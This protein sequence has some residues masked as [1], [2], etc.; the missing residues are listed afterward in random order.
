VSR[1]EWVRLWDKGDL[2]EVQ[3]GIRELNAVISTPG[4]RRGGRVEPL[5]G[6]EQLTPR[7][8][9]KGIAALL[10][11]PEVHYAVRG[12]VDPKPSPVVPAGFTFRQLAEECVDVPLVIPGGVEVEGG[13]V[14]VKLGRH[15]VSY[16]FDPGEAATSPDVQITVGLSSTRPSS[17]PGVSTRIAGERS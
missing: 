15:E 8:S 10:A 11:Q 14:V 4:Y 2:M 12:L 1:A 17:F 3:L 9:A 6:L 13:S 16:R 7:V 5:W